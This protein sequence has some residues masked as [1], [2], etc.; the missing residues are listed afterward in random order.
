MRGS[1]FNKLISTYD[2][3][4]RLD[5]CKEACRERYAALFD[6]V[7]SCEDEKLVR[8]AIRFPLFILG[9]TI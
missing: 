8:N 3:Y 7:L 5:L 9:K 2:V 4:N 6:N 1:E